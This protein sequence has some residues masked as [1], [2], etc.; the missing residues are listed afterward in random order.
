M[1]VSVK[2][3][4]YMVLLLTFCTYSSVYEIPALIAVRYLA[5]VL[6]LPTF[7]D[8][9]N[10]YHQHTTQKL[11]QRMGRALEDIGIG[12]NEHLDLRTEKITD[13]EGID[14]LTCAALEGAGMMGFTQQV[15]R[16]C[17]YGEFQKVI[18]LLIK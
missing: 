17:W 6:Q 10:T 5:G 4:I 16:P 8:E 7:W 1:L 18:E 12:C 13:L 9:R 11:F 15:A 3:L 14:A 2:M